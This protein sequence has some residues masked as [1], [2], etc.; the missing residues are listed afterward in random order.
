MF[1]HISENK[2]VKATI[3]YIANVSLN[4]V[5]VLKKDKRFTPLY[6]EVLKIRILLEDS[7]LSF[8]HRPFIVFI[9]IGQT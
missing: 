8:S 2:L 4:S 7:E 6:G 9:F 1:V 5:V 3:Y